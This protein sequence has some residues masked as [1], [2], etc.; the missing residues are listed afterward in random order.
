MSTERKVS[1]LAAMKHYDAGGKIASEYWPN[2]WIKKKSSKAF[3]TEQGLVD[4]ALSLQCIS[5]KWI[6]K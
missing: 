1:F 5:G 2:G 3:V 4:N 6:K